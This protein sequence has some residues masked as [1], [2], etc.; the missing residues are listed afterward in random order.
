MN[1]CLN[2]R[3]FEN[4]IFEITYSAILNKKESINTR[5]KNEINKI[6]YRGEKIHGNIEFSRGNSKPRRDS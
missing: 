1:T 3:Q 4:T 2:F 5:C 6:L